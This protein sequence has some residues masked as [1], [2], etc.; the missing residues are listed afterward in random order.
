MYADGK[1][2]VPQLVEKAYAGE[3]LLTPGKRSPLQPLD[4]LA[5]TALGRQGL[6]I[7]AVPAVGQFVALRRI[8]TT[9]W[10]GV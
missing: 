3:R 6:Q 8:E 7:D 2:T 9:A 5:L 4:E 10:G 1:L